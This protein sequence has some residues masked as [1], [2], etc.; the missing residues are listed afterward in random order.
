MKLLILMSLIITLS[1]SLFAQ[2]GGVDVGNFNVVNIPNSNLEL[3]IPVEWK[4]QL[5]GDSVTLTTSYN[6]LIKVK[7]ANFAGNQLLK[8]E[9]IINYM[10][11][12]T[13]RSYRK[14]VI[15]GLDSVEYASPNMLE[16]D[17]FVISPTNK[18]INFT[19]VVNIKD[20]KSFKTALRTIR[21][22]FRG[23][24]SLGHKDITKDIVVYTASG[25]D[26]NNAVVF[27]DE[28][29]GYNC[30]YGV[31]SSLT[32]DDI[33]YIGTSGYSTGK[34]IDLG[35]DY[36]DYDKINVSGDYILFPDT[37]VELDKIYSKF[38]TQKPTENLSRIKLKEGHVYLVRTI[39]WP[40]EDMLFKMRVDNLNSGKDMTIT[41]KRLVEVPARNLKRYVLDMNRYTE[42]VEAKKNSG[43]VTL[44][45]RSLWAGGYAPST[46]NFFYGTRDNQFITR[47]S[48]DMG[49]DGGSRSVFRCSNSRCEIF[50]LGGVALDKIYLK[51]FPEP[52]YIGLK[53]SRAAIE[54]GNT[55][56]IMS[57]EYSYDYDAKGVWAAFTILDQE[58]GLKRW[59][60]VKWKKFKSEKEVDPFILT[61]FHIDSSIKESSFKR[62]YGHSLYADFMGLENYCS[63]DIHLSPDRFS[64]GS[65][66]QGGTHRIKKKLENIKLNDLDE[67]KFK[68]DFFSRKKRMGSHYRKGHRYIYRAK[69]LWEDLVIA[70]EF[71]GYTAKDVTIRY[72]IL[73]AG[74]A[75]EGMCH[76]P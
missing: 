41:F 9:E 66:F 27:K 6:G 59:V 16:R 53:R 58:E 38:S 11:A 19:G 33:L 23:V 67:S 34:V 39:N 21:F 26:T 46:F 30:G 69:T 12:T 10:N 15:N 29:A 74:L 62:R 47:N 28:C 65:N 3:D 56:L 48:W 25:S 44:Y 24:K 57:Y 31:H 2:G 43:I 51:D 60:K 35:I 49:F 4:Q 64:F 42:E 45:D 37:K 32:S 63:S 20:T 7:P 76:S 1:F 22:K 75:I 8:A 40:E 55:Y 70:F 13:G 52:N 54:V 17:L 73:S 50:S 61:N 72:K 36:K 18:V 14:L 5:S 68:T 71:V